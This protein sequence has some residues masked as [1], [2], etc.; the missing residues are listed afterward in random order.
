MPHIANATKLQLGHSH[1]AL[2][3]N[4]SGASRGEKFFSPLLHLQAIGKSR[5]F[6]LR[7]CRH[8]HRV[9]ALA[10][11]AGR[12][13]ARG[14]AGLRRERGAS[15]GWGKLHLDAAISLRLAAFA[16]C[17]GVA[18]TIR[19]C[20]LSFFCCGLRRVCLLRLA[21]FAGCAGFASTIRICCLSFFCCGLRRVCLLWLARG[22]ICGHCG[23]CQQSP[24]LPSRFH[25]LWATPCVSVVA[26]AWRHL[27]ALRALPA[28]PASAAA[29]P[30]PLTNAAACHGRRFAALQKYTY[31]ASAFLRCCK[32]A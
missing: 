30:L 13:L 19:I 8:C 17:A 16:G 11:P 7:P 27:R 4:S 29:S 20:C 21:A 5:F 2:W 31:N 9:P 24:H 26:G 1:I 18:S 32:T 6:C 12:P 3:G 28:E 25:P 10:T 23:L 15:L 14:G 22:G